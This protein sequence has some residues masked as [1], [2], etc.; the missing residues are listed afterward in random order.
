MK[1]PPF[2]HSHLRLTLL[3]TPPDR[4]FL[5]KYHWSNPLSLFD[6]K[7]EASSL[8]NRCIYLII[9]WQFTPKHRS[10][11]VADWK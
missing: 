10:E 3:G 4:V 1:F 2:L 9:D 11:A 6:L 8:I 5:Y 7:K